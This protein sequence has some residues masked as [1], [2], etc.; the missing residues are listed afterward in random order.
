ME[1]K[2]VQ[3]FGVQRVLG[4]K[5]DLLPLCVGQRCLAGSV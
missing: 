3:C 4:G 5:G 1:D 2:Q